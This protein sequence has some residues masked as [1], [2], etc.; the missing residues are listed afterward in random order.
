MKKLG[1]TFILAFLSF[2]AI[3]QDRNPLIVKNDFQNQ[4]KWVDSLF[5]NMTLEEKMGQLFMVDIFSSDP[6][7]KTDKIKD[8]IKNYHI[9]GVIFSKGGPVRQ[10]KLN[11]EFQALAK[12]PLMVGM[13]AE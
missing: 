1:F 5:D 3:A 8:L 11:N 6:E 2:A 9:G 4:R 12:T 10:A 13:D 7:T